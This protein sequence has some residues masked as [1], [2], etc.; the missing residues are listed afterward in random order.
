MLELQDWRDFSI[1]SWYNLFSDDVIDSRII[2]ISDDLLNTLLN[3]N[4]GE[5]SEEEECSN[6]S[7]FQIRNELNHL[8][9]KVFVRN[10]WRSPSDA[11]AFSFGNTLT[12]TSVED[13]LLY[14]SVSDRITRD[15]ESCKG[16]PFCIVLRPWLNIHPATEFRC[17]VINKVL[18]GISPRDWPTYYAHFK[19]DGPQIIDKIH[20]FF[21]SKILKFPRSNYV[22]DVIL[23]L[24]D[25]PIIID[26]SPLN[27]KTNLLAFNWNEIYSIIKKSP[28]EE[29]APVFRYLESDIGIMTRANLQHKFSNIS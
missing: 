5:E 11:R 12:V 4:N 25:E 21:K 17:I 27:K 6:E 19:E 7:F 23:N 20:N 26:F 22:F 24:P 2:E 18:R 1:S 28:T 9:N 14:L 3:I 29:V 10:N 15:F 13:I 16:I 8:N